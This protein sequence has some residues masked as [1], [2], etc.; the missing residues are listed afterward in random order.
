MYQ[1]KITREIT[2]ECRFK[3]G[4]CKYKSQENSHNC[5]GCIYA[6]V[7]KNKLISIEK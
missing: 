7:I 2:F 1:E 4:L 3:E 6:Q 5:I